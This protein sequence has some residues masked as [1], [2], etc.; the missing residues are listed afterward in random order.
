MG[1]FVKFGGWIVAAV[2]MVIAVV[3]GVKLRE[4]H[5]Q[6]EIATRWKTELESQVQ[7]LK[8]SQTAV[9]A[10]SDEMELKLDE[11]NK[12]VASLKTAAARASESG[13]QSQGAAAFKELAKAMGA[14]KEQGSD[15]DSPLKG[16]ADMFKG[17]NGKALTKMSASMQMGMMYDPLFKELSL[18]PDAEAKAR[19]ILSKNLESQ[20][21]AGLKLLSGDKV[22]A[23]S[24]AKQEQDATKKMRDELG[25]V[26]SSDEL[27][28]YDQ[29]Q[30]EMP[31]HTLEQ[32][33]DIGLG[34]LGGSLK[35]E[36]RELIKQTLVE[37]TLAGDPNFGK[38]GSASKTDPSAAFGT[39][40]T[41]IDRAG[42]ACA[43]NWTTSS[44]RWPN[45]S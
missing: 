28:K 32:S 2:A 9:K 21:Q 16:I 42:S 1:A 33:Y 11:A 12:A 31:R 20:M 23:E 43:P 22:D 5:S 24:V 14:N 7:E 13:A 19:D 29:Y 18:S 44:L 4:A 41:A 40:I 10:K 6:Q 8:N 27:A 26:L 37:E 3:L 25:K 15:G 30:E 39:Q 36:S 38:P 17:E 45:A 34:M 35:T